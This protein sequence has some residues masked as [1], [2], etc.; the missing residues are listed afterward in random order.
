VRRPN[1]LAALLPDVVGIAEEAGAAVLI[2]YA[3]SDH[4]VREKGGRAPVTRSAI[5]V[6]SPGS[7]TGSRKPFPAPVT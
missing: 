2:V 1:D 7:P 4:A 6:G 5:P 3:Q